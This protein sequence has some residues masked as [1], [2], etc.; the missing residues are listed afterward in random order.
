MTG[1]HRQVIALKRVNLTD[2]VVSKLPRNAT[3]KTLKKCWTV[4]I[5]AIS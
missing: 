2:I 1:V 3:E 5:I 4:R